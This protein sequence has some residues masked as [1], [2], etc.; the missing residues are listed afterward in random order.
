V[1]LYGSEKLFGKFCFRGSSKMHSGRKWVSVPPSTS[2]QNIL[3]PEALLLARG[4]HSGIKWVSIPLCPTLSPHLSPCVPLCPPLSPS[5]F[6]CPKRGTA[7]DS[8]GQRGTEADRGG[9]KWNRGG[10][11]GDKRG[12]EGD[13]GEP[14]WAQGDT[15]GQ[16]GT[17]AAA[18][19]AIDPLP[20]PPAGQ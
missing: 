15:G 6:P 13:R 7:G 14:R 8:G 18:A 20:L 19:A 10:T 12:T 16:R 4:Q 3:T 9:A 1:A 11:E 5:W 2:T 17:A